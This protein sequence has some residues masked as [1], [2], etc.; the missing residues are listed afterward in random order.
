M[1]QPNY[2]LA[3]PRSGVGVDGPPTTSWGTRLAVVGILAVVGGMVWHL[4]R[5]SFGEKSASYTPNRGQRLTKSKLVEKVAVEADLDKREVRAALEA[6]RDV[7]KKQLGPGGAGEVTIPGV[8]KLRTKNV[9]A[10]KRR[11]G[12]NPFT[13][14]EQWFKAKPATKKVRA[15][16]LKDVREAA[17]KKPRKRA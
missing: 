11:R 2:S 16:I 1:Y 8:A 4:T 12:V 15:T 7:V 5:G 6:L 17:A 13:G 9:K 10:R 3:P 14:E